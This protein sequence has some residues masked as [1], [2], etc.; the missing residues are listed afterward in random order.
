MKNM[1]PNPVRILLSL[2]DAR[3]TAQEQPP[4]AGYPFG[5]LAG[6]AVFDQRK[7][8]GRVIG[9]AVVVDQLSAH[10]TQHTTTTA[11]SNATQRTTTTAPSNATQHTTTTM[12]PST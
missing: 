4:L 5:V 10:A 8:H 6:I 11:P 1:H 2:V 3:S 12:G 9:A 7:V